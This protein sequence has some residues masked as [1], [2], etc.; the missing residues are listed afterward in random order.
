[1]K[2]SLL[3]SLLFL[4]Q[5]ACQTTQPD[6][7]VTLLGTSDYHSHA[8]PFYSEGKHDQAGI[9]RA[10]AYFKKAR[11]TPGTLV[12]SGGDTLNL[13]TP[14]WSDEY[15]CI[16]WAW[17]NGV[18]D[19]M[20]VGNHEFDYGPE[21]FQR[22][23]ASVD[24][25]LISSN[26]VGADGQ[27]LLRPDGKPYVIREVQGVR[28]GFFA[29]GGS[30]FPRLIR[31]HLLP[32]G[33]SWKEPIA[34]A[35][36][37]VRQLREVEKVDAVVFIGHQ[38]RE[39]DE[40]MARAAPG[41]DLILGSHSHFKSELVKIPGTET[42]FISPY[43]YLT[44][45]SQVRLR[46]RQG[47]QVEVTGE[48]VKMDENQPKDEQLEA[49]VRQLQDQLVAKRPERFQ[50]LGRALV[51]LGDEGLSQHE[52]VLGNWA[53]EVLRKAA[54]THAYFSTASSFRAGIPPG[55]ITVETF[56]TAIPYKNTVVTA[57][58][59]GE[60]LL[61]WL[62]LSVSKRGSDI[63]S[64]QTGVRYRAVEG[65]LT[66]VQVLVDPARPEVGYAPLVPG[67]SYRLATTNYQAFVAAGYKELFASFANPVTT[68]LDAHTVLSEA[69][70]AG[71]VTA[72]LDGRSGGN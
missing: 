17:L 37:T 30:D 64:Q 68:T 65:D 61:A 41:I 40:A 51:E 49:Q 24:Y 52:T 5:T 14:T 10:M 53:T 2:K 34:E 28:V 20:A 69:L 39:E 13:G 42:Y 38:F 71:P 62:R 12:I 21:E 45:I 1:M 44:Y 54:G 25:P 35:Q 23:A 66:Q 22:C 55:D 9:A 31:S 60:Q 3:P 63:F 67:A 46:F 33:A 59:T 36:A 32:E 16:E 43:Q 15:R 70:R 57:D 58:V 56:Y 8:V 47:K 19:I 4:A 11:Q 72:E 27:P 26:L 6:V 7:V 50:V 48:L 29:L 18:V